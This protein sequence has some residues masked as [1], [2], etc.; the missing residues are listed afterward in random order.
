MKAITAEQMAR[1][2][3]HSI[4]NGIKKVADAYNPE[5]AI[6]IMIGNLVFEGEW[7]GILMHPHNAKETAAELQAG[8][9]ISR[10]DLDKLHGCFEGNMDSLSEEMREI[11][12]KVRGQNG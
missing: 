6:P 10:A 5:S 3:F 2:V 1:G 4:A 9:F 8:Y 12:E 11:I 7:A